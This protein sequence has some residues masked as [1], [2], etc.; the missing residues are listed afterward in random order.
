MKKFSNIELKEKTNDNTPKNVKS[1]N[2]ILEKSIQ[3]NITSDD[4][5]Y[6][7]ENVELSGTDTLSVELES[8]LHREKLKNSYNL[9]NHLEASM[10]NCYNDRLINS[11]IK[12]LT[13]KYKDEIPNP[14]DVFCNEDIETRDNFILLKN[15][16]KIPAESYADILN[17]NA[18]NEYFNCGNSVSIRRTEDNGWHLSFNMNGLLYEDYHIF[19]MKGKNFIS[20]FIQATSSLIGESNITLDNVLITNI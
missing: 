6:I 3:I 13:E 20:D 2:N 15:I 11:F 19:V 4:I 14:E 10:N 18:T 5:K 9:L 1:F 8:L 17:M 12:S 7:K 16:S